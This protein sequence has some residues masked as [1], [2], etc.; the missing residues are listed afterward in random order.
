MEAVDSRLHRVSAQKFSTR[1]VILIAI[2]LLACLRF[3][4]IHLLWADEDYHLVT[5]L[6]MLH[7]KIPYRD[8]WYD[9]PPLSAIYYLLIGGY[10]GW[11]LR[12]LDAA[13]VMAACAVTYRLAKLWW[14]RTEALIAA[15]LLSF[16]L[17]FYL[18]SAV[19]PFAA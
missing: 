12:A 9:K 18:P 1:A 17:A 14:S 8:F 15:S 16:Y 2:A 6:Q 4:H 5:A 10:S 13:Y 19:I 3:A 11:L 7:G